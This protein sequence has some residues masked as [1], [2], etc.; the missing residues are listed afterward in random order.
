MPERIFRPKRAGKLIG[1]M[2]NYILR[3]YVMCTFHPVSAG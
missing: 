3:R 2:K 1:K